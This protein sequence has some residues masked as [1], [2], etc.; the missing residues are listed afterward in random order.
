MGNLSPGMTLDLV[1]G[2][3]DSWHY[4][5]AFKSQECRLSLDF[6]R[7]NH[8]LPPP[9]HQGVKFE[10]KHIDTLIKPTLQL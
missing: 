6:S 2:E 4:F 9:M 7:D 10:F 5:I 8:Q 1:N 3:F